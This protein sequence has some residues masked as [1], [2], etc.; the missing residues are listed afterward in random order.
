MFLNKLAYASNLDT[1]RYGCQ[2][3]Q[4]NSEW[5]IDDYTLPNMAL[6]NDVEG[7]KIVQQYSY[8]PIR[9]SRAMCV[10]NHVVAYRESG[11]RAIL[12][13]RPTWNRGVRG[14]FWLFL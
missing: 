12:N 11:K 6:K 8:H 1:S 14:L 9:E 3:P 13:R 5:L 7:L 10:S 2:L 4:I